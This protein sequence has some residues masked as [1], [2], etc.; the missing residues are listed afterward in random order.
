MSFDLHSLSF[1]TEIVGTI[2]FSIS[3]AMLA[4]ER[5]LDLFG[6]VFL[7][8]VTAIGGGII[9]DLLLGQIPPQAFL[10]YVY[11][12]FAVLTALVVFVIAHW[13]ARRGKSIPFINDTALNIFD[14]AGLGIF[15]VIG[16]QNTI[17]AGFGENAFFC[18]FL[19]LTTGVG[20]GMLRDVLS[21]STP[22][23]LRKHIYAL[24]SLAGALCYYLLQLYAPAISIFMSTLLVVI[25]R[26]L[27]SH[28]R[29]TLPRI[30]IQ[31]D[32]HSL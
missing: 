9:R 13:R 29:W 31:R 28:Y 10:N 2:A 8:A 19:G 27:A 17:D 23:V 24:A 4:I 26:V 21:R 11:L 18:V 14:A 15:S 7:G 32:E 12:L 6:V 5:N 30:P 3:G 22:A 1:L 20:G 25:L 16:V